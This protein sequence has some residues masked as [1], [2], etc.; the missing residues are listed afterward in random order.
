MIVL[1]DLGLAYHQAGRVDEALATYRKALEQRPDLALSSSNL[2]NLLA[3]QGKPAEAIAHYRA[4]LAADPD[5]KVTQKALVDPYATQQR[6]DKARRK[7]RPTMTGNVP[8]RAATAGTGR[9]LR[10]DLVPE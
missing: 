4:A 6:F 2:G 10:Y 9:E 7:L 1:N 5:L 8:E 3:A